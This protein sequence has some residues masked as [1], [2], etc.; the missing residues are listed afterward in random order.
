MDT[1]RPA[2]PPRRSFAADALAPK[3]GISPAEV[4]QRKAFLEFGAA[5]VERVASI[6]GLARAYAD[7]VIGEFYEHLLAFEET[8]VFFDDPAVLEHVTR[9][10]KEYFLGLTSGDYGEDYIENRLTIGA[11]HEQ[12]GLP[13]KAYL[14]M[15]NFYL[16]AVATRLN[17]AFA[18]DPEQATE[19]FHSLMKL[20]FLDIGLAIDTYVFQREQTIRHQE[21]AIRE[22]STPALQIRDRLLILPI[23]GVLDSARA[24][25]LTDGLLRSIRDAR[26]K[27]VILDVTGVPT[28]DSTVANH[29]IQTVEASRLMGAVVIVTGLSAGVARALVMIGVDLTKFNAVGDLQGGL[30]VANKILGY[31]VVK[32]A[33]DGSDAGTDPQTR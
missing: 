21:E 27:V 11:V 30:E 8:A 28:V 20:V 10:Q 1:L 22:L 14:G 4:E 9:M 6:D 2:V 29:L 15:Y 18:D 19:A 26:A 32:F 24:Y 13:V 16:R 7:P 31:K 12:V 33:E 23:I 25:Q 5:D 17:E 3:M